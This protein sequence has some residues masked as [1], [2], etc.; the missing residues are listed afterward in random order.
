MVDALV[1]GQ[2]IPAVVHHVSEKYD[3]VRTRRLGGS[4]GL[5]Q[6]KV[7]DVLAKRHEPG[8]A[9]RIRIVIEY[10]RIRNNKDTLGPCT[11][12]DAY[13]PSAFRHFRA[14]MKNARSGEQAR[15]MCR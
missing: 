3:R 13:L 12:D 11:L 4:P 15:A 6:V 8:I 10:L 2:V 14:K 5:S 7:D 9:A 1:G